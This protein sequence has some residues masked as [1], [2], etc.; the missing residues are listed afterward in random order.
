MYAALC[1][2]DRRRQEASTPSR[3]SM[4]RSHLQGNLLIRHR[5]VTSS[6]YGLLIPYCDPCASSDNRL[7]MDGCYT[8]YYLASYLVVLYSRSTQYMCSTR[9]EPCCC[10]RGISCRCNIGE[11]SLQKH[12][13]VRCDVIRFA[14]CDAASGGERYAFC[15]PATRRVPRASCVDRTRLVVTRLT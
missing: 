10:V 14:D 15:T 7:D 2:G 9:N 5:M 11:F 4:Y 3:F 1:R 6:S 8:T 12:R 13:V